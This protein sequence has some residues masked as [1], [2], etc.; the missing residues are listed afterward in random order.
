MN[1]FLLSLCL[2][3]CIATASFG[4]KTKAK[5]AEKKSGHKTDESAETPPAVEDPYV[6]GTF[7]DTWI[8]NLHT[9]ETIRPRM[10]S[11]R[12]SHRLGAFDS[13]FLNLFGLDGPASI[14][15]GSEWGI[16]KGLMVGAGRSSVGK[17]WDGYV[18]YRF[19]TQRKDN[20]I[21]LNVAV[22]AK[23]NITQD[24]DFGAASNGFDRYSNFAHRMSYITQLII[25]RKIID[26]ISV[27]IAPG[28]IHYNL[29]EATGF[30]NSIFT[31]SAGAKISISKRVHLT[32]EY[33]YVLNKHVPDSEKNRFFN[34]VGLGCEIMT[35]GH[36]FQ[37]NV[38]NSFAT[39][40]TQ[41]FAYSLNNPLK[42]QIRLG[43][44]IQRDFR[45]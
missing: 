2:F 6:Y 10:F 39:N 40:D 28:Y 11:V 18:K 22:Y 3:C 42:G 15:L 1:K 41:A 12:I 19:L 38:T 25:S 23:A 44:N 43:F 24:K 7:N 33:T 17:L 5:K 37:I 32:G 13:G 31:L 36:V 21:P 35:G 34:S 8:V 26:R 29:T 4:Q 14:R 45:Y 30:K 9:T 27:E 20:K 16:I